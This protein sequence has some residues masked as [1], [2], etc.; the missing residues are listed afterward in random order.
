MNEQSSR[1]EF[2]EAVNP[3]ENEPIRD[4]SH[5]EVIERL[6]TVGQLSKNAFE[7]S[8]VEKLKQAYEDRIA[9]NDDNRWKQSVWY[10][11]GK[12]R[13]LHME[14]NKNDIERNWEI[15]DQSQRNEVMDRL[16]EVYK[17]NH[18]ISNDLEKAA[19]P[20]MNKDEGPVRE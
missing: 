9:A 10:N 17:E 3:R 8:E 18:S 19:E 11:S 14:G 15:E 1:E 5:D 16:K 6:K 7:H 12:G 13:W 20:N 4:Y 2:N